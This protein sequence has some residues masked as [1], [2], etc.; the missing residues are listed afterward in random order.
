VPQTLETLFQRCTRSS[1]HALATFCWESLDSFN[2]PSYASRAVQK[3]RA[4]GSVVFLFAVMIL[5]NK[6]GTHPSLPF[7]G[8]P[9]PHKEA[10]SASTTRVKPLVGLPEEGHPSSFCCSALKLEFGYKRTTWQKK[11]VCTTVTSSPVA[12]HATRQPRS[13]GQQNA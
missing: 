5:T 2:T 6:Q 9:F 11:G 13:K 3:A 7:V 1:V 12:T 10:F 4:A 8:Y